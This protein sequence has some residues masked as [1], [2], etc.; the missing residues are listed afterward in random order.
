MNWKAVIA[1]E[2]STQRAFFEY[3]DHRIA[4]LTK[5]CASLHT[6]DRDHLIARAQLDEMQR[7]KN[8]P[9]T[10]RMEREQ[11]APAGTNPR[12]Y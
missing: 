1:A 8:L 9:E 5:K 4:E 2:G 3:A 10:L 11:A 6:S 7:L 12:G